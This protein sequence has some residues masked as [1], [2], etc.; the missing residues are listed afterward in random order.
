MVNLPAPLFVKFMFP[1]TPPA[2]PPDSTS[3]VLALTLISKAVDGPD[4][5]PVILPFPCVLMRLPPVAT[6]TLLAK[7]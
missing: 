5:V 3:E 6:L 2:T 4:V 1:A 7:V